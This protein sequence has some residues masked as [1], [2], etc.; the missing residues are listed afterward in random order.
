MKVT[1]SCNTPRFTY[2]FN[3]T[4]RGI[5]GVYG[6]SGSGKSSLL[7]AL[8]GYNDKVKGR[9]QYHK[10]IILDTDNKCPP[11]VHKCCYMQQNPVM[12]PHW[13]VQQHLAFIR[14]H[15][16]PLTDDFMRQDELLVSLNCQHLLHK[17][18]PQL[19]G[20][21]KQRI[22]YILTLLQISK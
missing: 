14:Q 6:I 15:N 12:F 17:Y 16:P 7:D 2:Q 4:D 11:Q 3:S 19:S 22:V 20:G 18:P 8:A 13:T 10:R 1:I 9:I 5:V 21:E